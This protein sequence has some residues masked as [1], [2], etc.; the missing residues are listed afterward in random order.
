MEKI[1]PIIFLVLI[2]AYIIFIFSRY[3]RCPADKLMVIYGRVGNDKNG[4]PRS[5]VCIHGGAAFIWPIIQR[6]EYLD[7][8]PIKVEINLNTLTKDNISIDIEARLSIGIS[9]EEGIRDNAVE[10]LLGLKLEHIHDLTKDILIGILRLLVNNKDAVIINLNSDEFLT[11]FV[12]K[13]NNEVNKIGINLISINLNRI[14][15]LG[16]VSEK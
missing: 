2:I 10:R 11:E 14:S 15:T 9:V 8:N 4:E 6:Y 5:Y 1:L 3:R 16:G 7:L 12:N 13:A